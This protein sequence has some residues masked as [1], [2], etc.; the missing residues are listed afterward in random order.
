MA[1]LLNRASLASFVLC[2]LKE[3]G[4]QDGFYK[5]VKT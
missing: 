3:G 5:K 2:F 1:F 4:T